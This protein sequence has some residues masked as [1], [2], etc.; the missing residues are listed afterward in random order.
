MKCLFYLFIRIPTIY[1]LAHY[2]SVNN[3][4]KTNKKLCMPPRIVQFFAELDSLRCNLRQTSR[5]YPQQPSLSP[6]Y[7]LTSS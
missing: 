6:L 3:I 2:Y 4:H 7:P 1:K 5:L